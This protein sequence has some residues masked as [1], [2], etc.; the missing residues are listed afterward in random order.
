MVRISQASQAVNSSGEQICEISNAL[1]AMSVASLPLPAGGSTSALQ[2]AGNSSLA[3]VDGKIT[4]CD[5]GAVV[6]SS[7]ALPAGG[8]T[9]TLQTAG[10][11]SLSAIDTKLAGTLTVSSTVASV[12]GSNNNH[13]NNQSVT[14][15]YQSSG[16]DVSSASRFSIMGNT[17][18]QSQSILIDVSPDNTNW[19]RI[20]TSLYPVWTDTVSPFDFYE[21]FDGA[22]VS[23]VRLNFQNYTGTQTVNATILVQ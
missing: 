10:N 13:L 21:S 14:S 23:Y 8:A 9:S 4:T 6:V 19:Y 17:T 18:E 11:S 1:L 5:T 7:S 2:T 3:S 20:N 16:F 22:C 12:S 15:A